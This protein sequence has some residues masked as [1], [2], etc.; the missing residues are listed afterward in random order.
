MMHRLFKL[1]LNA[2][3]VGVLVAVGLMLLDVAISP[4]QSITWHET[5]TIA[6]IETIMLFSLALFETYLIIKGL[7]ELDKA[8]KLA[9]AQTA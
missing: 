6:A 3:I 5:P 4:T 9:T 1:I 8:T 2:M 7:K